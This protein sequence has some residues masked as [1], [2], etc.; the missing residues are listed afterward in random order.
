VRKLHEN[1]KSFDDYL[2]S[3]GK[4]LPGGDEELAAKL[5][6]R[7]RNGAPITRFPT[8]AEADG[9]EGQ[10]QAA[11][12]AIASAKTQL[13]RDE[14]KRRFADLNARFVAFDYNKDLDGARCPVGAHTRRNNPRGALEFGKR[15]AFAT[16]GAVDN[17]R[18]ILRR[19]LPYGE[20]EKDRRDEGDHGIVFMAINAS[21]RRQF[22]FVQQQWVNYGN[23][24]KLGNDKDPIAGNHG[25]TSSGEPD[26]R[27]LIET[28]ANDPSPPLLCGAMP[29]F[30][31]TRGG[32]Y[33]FIPGLNALR[34][35]AAGTIDPT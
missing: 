31:E 26:G 13:E 22:E 35:I 17:R 33:F 5:A 15:G 24:F 14:A 10:W 27:M 28:A 30:V 21:L 3:M 23:D 7:W 9:F 1:T 4:E 6:G 19:G 11:K 29:R 12:L 20:S 18:R 25:T 8:R 32:D 2:A 16:I 34:M